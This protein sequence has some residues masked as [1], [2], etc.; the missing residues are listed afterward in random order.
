MQNLTKDRR[1]NNAVGSSFRITEARVSWAVK[2]KTAPDVFT[3]DNRKELTH[4]H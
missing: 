4:A 1:S 2:G 3:T